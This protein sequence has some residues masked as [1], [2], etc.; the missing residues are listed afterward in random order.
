LLLPAT[1][2][3]AGNDAEDDVFAR[4]GHRRL[5]RMTEPG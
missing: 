1:V 2:V 4:F 3:N 5:R